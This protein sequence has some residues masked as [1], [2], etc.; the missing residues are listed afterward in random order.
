MKKLTTVQVVPVPGRRILMPERAFQPVPAKGAR[1]YLDAF[2]TRTINQGDL[3]VV[4]DT[5]PAAPA[6]ASAPA[7]PAAAPLAP[8]PT[9]VSP[10]AFYPAPHA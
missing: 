9:P 8:A 7:A 3:K 1:V 6:V 5:A 4:P 10:A 2:Y